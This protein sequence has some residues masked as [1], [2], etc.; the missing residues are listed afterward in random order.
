MP[1]N[2]KDRYRHLYMPAL[3]LVLLAIPCHGLLAQSG[4]GSGS[5]L[6]FP[7]FVS[8][9][10]LSS[11]M[12][13]FNPSGTEATA[14]FTLR[15]V[16]GIF[17][18]NATVK[19]PPRG[20]VAKTAGELFPGLAGVEGSIL[21]TSPTSGLIPYCLTYNGQLSMIDGGGAS[22]LS[23]ELLFPVIPKSGEGTGEISIYNPNE[24]STAVDLSL[25]SAAGDLLGKTTVRILAG[26][27]Y[28]N[29]PESIFPA[30]T[31]FSAA[32]H[33]TAISQ[34]VNIFGQAQSIA[35]SSSFAGF[36]SVLLPEGS[37]DFGAVNAQPLSSL[38]NTGVIPHFRTGSQYASTFCLANVEPSAVNITLTAVGNN[39]AT[40]GTKTVSVPALGGL[41]SPMQSLFPTLGSGERQ[42]WVLMQS[43]GRV[44]ATILFGKSNGGALS[45]VPIQQ[46]PMTDIVFP[47]VLHG[48]DNSMEI[49]MVNPSAMTAYVG[50]Y[51]VHPMGITLANN[52]IMLAPGARISKSLS[53]LLPE[54]SSQAGGYI[55]L[56]STAPIFS[57][58]SIWINNEASVASIAP[59]PVTMAYAPSKLSN[60]AVTGF[61]T[62]NGN[63]AQGLRMVL[64]GPVG[65]LAI[66]GADG[67]YAFTGLPSGHYSMA[68]DQSGFESFFTQINF[69]IT[70]AS[71]RQ[72]FQGYTAPN[73]IVVQP[74]SL[75]VKSPA[76]VLDVFGHGFNN[77]SLA[78][79]GA[80]QLNTSFVDATHLTAV[81]PSYLLAS[82][83]RLEITVETG[84][85]VSQVYN[86]IVY[87]DRP[88]L[89]SLTAAGD[90]M[91]GNAGTTLMLRGS[92]FIPGMKVVVNGSSDDISVNVV[93][94]TEAV[95]YMPA[96]Y[97]QHGGIFPVVV[98]NSFPSNI[99]SNVQLLTVYFA[100]PGIEEVQPGAVRVRLE[101]GLGSANVEIR[102]FGFK[103]GAIAFLGKTALSTRY[104]EDDD[105]CLATR[106]YASIPAGL[107]RE[108]GFGQ[109]TVQNPSP[110]L[111]SSDAWFLK[112]EGL[113]PTIESVVPGSATIVGSPVEFDMPIVIHGTNFG[114]Q[115]K[116]AIYRSGDEPGFESPDEVLSST[117]LYIT[118]PVIYPDSLG[119]WSVL[120]MNPP[121][122]GGTS[123][124]TGFVLSEE[125]FDSSPFLISLEPGVVAAG[126]PGFTL[127]LKG[128]NFAEGAQVQ[129]FS[130]LLPATVDNRTAATVDI[131]AYLI[132]YAGRFP[133]KV[134]NPDNGGASNRLYLEVR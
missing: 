127:T 62:L 94:S 23:N 10:T 5:V 68:V 26:G 6:L 125:N 80:V 24:R 57:T 72:D 117:Q 82:P 78:Y 15:N 52:Q 53:Q 42:G 51:V 115:T 96:R 1:N 132:R 105:Y 34:P 14:T 54:I 90:I 124:G 59:Q 81:L 28:H 69:E 120:V 61:V 86:F 111:G 114:P 123:L 47:Q 87:Q 100:S 48:A 58:A 98:Q 33:I 79:A 17:L 67:A 76:G 22:G 91:E 88:T 66:T 31:N 11:G 13:V 36:S 97:F 89:T 27:L 12:A 116:V 104:C 134:I 4:T 65:K 3:L 2:S 113:Q 30:G 32:S 107:L 37:L 43:S 131:P 41:R 55:Y 50:V 83:A 129:F 102:G 56:E 84:G 106:L 64:S 49:S 103:R 63:P 71:V 99:V 126:G 75:P 74:G 95:A 118:I 93:D 25:W 130:T 60:Y 21:V 92:G 29:N 73:A 39:G 110:T 35:G 133:I 122:G 109:I 8:N 19:I 85:I 108:S 16:D 38:T 128:N 121:P 112:I 7:R 77:A 9:Q 44:H 119:A 70:T 101:P 45:A 20:Q 40:L 46:L 18:T